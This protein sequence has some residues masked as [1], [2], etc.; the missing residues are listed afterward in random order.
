MS[1]ID[2]SAF[3]VVLVVLILNCCYL[4]HRF[5]TGRNLNSTT[6]NSEVCKGNFQHAD[7][8]KQGLCVIY[9][10]AP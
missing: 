1:L 5:T 8:A 6:I 7:S 9:L 10:R 4:Q 3:F 2:F